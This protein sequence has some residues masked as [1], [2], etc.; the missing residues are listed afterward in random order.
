MHSG[1]GRALYGFDTQVE[2]FAPRYRV[3]TL[4]RRGC[5]QSSRL[6]HFPPDFHERAAQDA[7]DW[8]AG[9]RLDQAIVWG[10]SDGAVVAAMMGIIQPE[11]VQALILE[12]S[13]YYRDK[14]GS[15]AF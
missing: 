4:D 11:R 2:Y 15:L 13:H 9:L 6:T 10:H 1:W 8:M 14:T 7:L 3:L 5:G 12:G